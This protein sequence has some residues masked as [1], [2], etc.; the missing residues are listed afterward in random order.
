MPE[1]YI[2]A[3]VKY[4][5]DREYQPLKPRQLARQMGV[6][7]GDYG[8][9]RSAIKQLRDAGRIVMGAKNALMLPEMSSRVIGH[10]RANPRGFGFVIPEH[11]NAH[12]DLFI[13]AD[14]AGGAMTGDLVAA[15]VSRKKRRGAETMFS[16][17]IVEI[18][19]RGQHRYVGT[20]EHTQGT[21]FVMP[22]GTKMT[23]PIVIRDVGAA[24]PGENTKV[25][26]E[27]VNYGSPGQLPQG[28]IIETLGEP[29]DID[30]ETTGVIRGYGL[31]SEFPPEVL[32]A[33]RTAL[34]AF[35]PATID[36]RTDL[37]DET[38]VTIDPPDARDYDDAMSF[39]DNGDGTVTLG[40]HIAD[41]SNFVPEGS[42]LDAEARE[43]STSVYFPRKVLP[44]LPE[45]LSNGICSLQEGQSRFAKSVFITYDGEANVTST[46]FVESVIRSSKR[47][48]YI[49]AQG[50]I[51]GKADGVPGKVVELLKSLEKLAKL[52][53]ARRRKAGMLHLDLP[54][55]ELVFDD[56]GNITISTCPQPSLCS[57]GPAGW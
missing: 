49:E 29:G 51:D 24:G 34:D 22:D 31:R 39:R 15:E 47:L 40:V 30:V 46:R 42:A 14:A 23:T 18:L 28:V 19:Q 3:I 6:T 53:E 57:T 5:S 45:V 11:P 37:T 36:G 16:G 35:D 32:Q 4:L 17:K 52:V 27:I 44:M 12:G 50:I 9:F 20:L 33:A 41:V 26:A 8:T 48:T 13:P 21:W 25:V 54:E 38:I 1:R 55:I 2:D 7:E 10:Y 56:A 43:R